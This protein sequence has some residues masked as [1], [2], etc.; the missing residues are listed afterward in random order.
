VQELLPY[1]GAR[2][3]LGCALWDL[4]M[5]QAGTSIWQYLNLTPKPLVTVATV[6]INQAQRR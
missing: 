4:R 3:A 6:G 2:N 1:G 5:K